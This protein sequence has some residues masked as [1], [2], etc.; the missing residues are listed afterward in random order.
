[1]GKVT[2]RAGVHGALNRIK[3]AFVIQMCVDDVCSEVMGDLSRNHMLEIL[4]MP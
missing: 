1:M 2:T 4:T 3:K